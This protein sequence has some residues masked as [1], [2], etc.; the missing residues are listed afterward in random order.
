METYL[1]ILRKQTEGMN[2]NLRDPNIFENG[3]I[4]YIQDEN[5]KWIIFLYSSE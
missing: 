2:K 1:S 4:V 5:G 3:E